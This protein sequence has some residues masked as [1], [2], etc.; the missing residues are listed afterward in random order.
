MDAR[1]RRIVDDTFLMLLNAHHEPLPF[2]LPAHRRS[3]RWQ[4][5][6]DTRSPDGRVDRQSLKGGESYELEGRSLALL[7]LHSTGEARRRR[8]RTDALRRQWGGAA[9]AFSSCPD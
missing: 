9:R 6:V 1:G 4:A 3:V 8:R 2:V 7:R 5:V